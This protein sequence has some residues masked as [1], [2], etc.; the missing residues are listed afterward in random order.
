MFAQDTQELLAEAT[1]RAAVEAATEAT[2]RA[3][4]T[5]EER[6]RQLRGELYIIVT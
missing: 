2:A 5:A 3:T 1:R 6:D 4:A